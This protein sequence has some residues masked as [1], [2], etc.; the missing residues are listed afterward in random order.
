ML[1]LQEVRTMYNP[2]LPVRVFY[3]IFAHFSIV[4]KCYFNYLGLKYTCN[5]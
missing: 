3:F 4:F 2:N 1:Q 5:L